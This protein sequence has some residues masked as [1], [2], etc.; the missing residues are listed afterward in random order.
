M[1]CAK[2]HMADMIGIQ[3]TYMEMQADKMVANMNRG[4]G[5]DL[6]YTEK[7]TLK[8]QA[9]EKHVTEGLKGEK[10]VEQATAAV[11]TNTR[12]F[13]LSFKKKNQPTAKQLLAQWKVTIGTI[14]QDNFSASLA[15]FDK[16][17]NLLKIDVDMN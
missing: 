3:A 8:K 12:S 6:S 9:R 17:A 15:E 4:Y 1:T 2:L 10:C 11:S 5:T 16:V 7:L 14:G 13:V